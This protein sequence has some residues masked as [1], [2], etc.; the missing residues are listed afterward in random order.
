M[1]NSNESSIMQNDSSDQILDSL[2]GPGGAFET[3]DTVID[4]RTVRVF[5]DAPES[6]A[7]FIQQGRKHGDETFIVE[8][9]NRITFNTYFEHVDRLAS[10]LNKIL[11]GSDRNV[12]ALASRNNANWMIAFS[13]IVLSGAIPALINSRGTGEN[14]KAA[15]DDGSA[16]LLLADTQRLNALREAGCE[17][18]AIC[19]DN[20]SPEPN[21]LTLEEA[22]SNSEIDYKVQIANKNDVAVLMYTSGTTGRAKAAALSN[23]SMVLG[24]MNTL[25]ARRA[26][27]ERMAQAY[28]IEMSILLSQLPQGS[29]LLVF[30]L[31][32]TS[33]CSAL[34]L[35]S[36]VNGD[37]LVL[38]PRWDI[39][40]A[41]R[42][43]ENENVTSMTAVP[44]MLWDFINAPNR[45]EFD[46]SSLR[47]FSSGG[48]GI[49]SPLLSKLRKAYPMA[50]FGT[51]YGMTEANGSVAQAIGEDFLNRPDAA[52]K[53]L[54]MAEVKVVDDQ[55]RRLETDSIGEIWVRSASL[56]N[57][58]WL[59]GD[60]NNPFKD[61]DWYATGDI[62]RV[63]QDGY[64]YILDRKTDMV[65]SGGENIY[66]A[67]IEQSLNGIEGVSEIVAFGI[68]DDR[69]GEILILGVV[70]EVMPDQILPSINLKIEE[71]IAPYKRPV[72]IYFR[73]QP[74][75][76]NAM[77]KVEKHK[78][79]QDYLNRTS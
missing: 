73:N 39:T 28:N 52:G 47:S 49:P 63:D 65:I 20:I 9:G 11:E 64:I 21:T 68:P 53:I 42:V 71:S 54:P 66:C 4:G 27:M 50:M 44:A 19:L 67:E 13:A 23:L 61:D 55:D 33:G 72:D 18:S 38:L 79:R 62:G 3:R 41:F 75:P 25:L 51:G 22:I 70:S 48:Q 2:L 40:N 59:K 1:R 60:I 26:I 77:D 58:Y 16:N 8:S 78:V 14:M 57:G 46:L 31:F 7:E 24:V 32:H 17:L 69:M 29:S 45:M 36:L 5:A 56:M 35:S 6:L 30:P 34:F 15:I 37:K 10:H 12:V 76:R 74:L 43:I